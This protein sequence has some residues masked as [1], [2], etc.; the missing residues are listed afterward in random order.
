M[1]F[2]PTLLHLNFHLHREQEE[3][4][5]ETGIVKKIAVYVFRWNV[6]FDVGFILENILRLKV[7]NVYN[8]MKSGFK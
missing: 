4:E 5:L 1:R 2:L 8:R 7:C 6:E 3:A